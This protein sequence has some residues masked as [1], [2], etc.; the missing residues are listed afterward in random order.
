MSAHGPGPLLFVVTE[1]MDMPHGTET[2][3]ALVLDTALEAGWRV[4]LYTALYRRETSRWRDFLESRGI[5]PRRP[6]FWRLTRFHLPHRL[7][8][9]RLWR[10]A[11]RCRPA[12]VWSPDNEPLTCRA[13]ESAPRGAPPFIVHDPSEASPANPHYEP[14]W[15]EACHRATGLSVHGRRQAASA[16]RHYRLRCPVEAVWPASF[17]PAAAGGGVRSHGRLRF[18]QFGRLEAPKNGPLSVEALARVAALGH[19]CELHFFGAGPDETAI[20]RRAAALDVGPRVFLHG[21]YAGPDLDRLAGGV[22]VGLM[23]SAYEGFGLV[24]LELMSRGRPVIASDVGSSREVLQDLGGGW[25]FD[26]GDVEGLAACMA[27]CCEDRP[28]VAAAGERARDVWLAHFQPRAMFARHVRFWRACGVEVPLPP[29]GPGR[30]W[31]A[32]SHRD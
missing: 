4:A 27:R 24:M 12:L 21:A 6:G 26:R 9:R 3:A 16:R 10:D 7:V 17:P 14:R 22:D 29:D 19:D 28:A 5:E 8:A 13:L 2:L 11:A 32:E 15:F 20:R 30:P 1:Q 23:P 18:G 25:V 31:S